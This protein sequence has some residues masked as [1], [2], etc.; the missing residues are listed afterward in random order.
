[1]WLE[2]D[3]GTVV[4]LFSCHSS[5]VLKETRPKETSNRSPTIPCRS[6]SVALKVQ[7]IQEFLIEYELQP[8]LTPYHIGQLSK[9]RFTRST[10]SRIWRSAKLI[11]AKAGL[12]SSTTVKRF[13]WMYPR[14][15]EH[16]KAFM[17]FSG[18]E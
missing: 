9:Y 12:M 3:S 16:E 6:V 17:L 15:M 14:P 2:A 1:M 7:F 4:L 5:H 10:S 11:L 18:G 8:K 13:T